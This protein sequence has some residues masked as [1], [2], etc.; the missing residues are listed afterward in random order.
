MIFKISLLTAALLTLNL[1]AEEKPPKND[2]IGS[3][4]VS[5]E[6]RKQEAI[7][8]RRIAADV[9]IL[10]WRCK[11]ITISG[12]DLRSIELAECER[13]TVR[14][15]W[16][17]DSARIGVEI[18]K[19]RQVRVE[20]CRIEN[21]MSGV[22]AVESQQVQVVENFV[23]NVK[24]PFPRGQ[25]VQFDKVSGADNFIR[26]N[27]ATNEHR[28]SHP[29]DVISIYLSSGEESSPIL[30]E[31]NYLTGDSSRGSEGMS[32][33]GSGIM[34]GDSGGGHMLCRRNVILS[35]GQ[36]GIGVA[37]G[38]FIRIEDNLIHGQ[39]SNVSNVGLYVWNQSGQPSRNVSV[40]RNRVQWL[41]RRGE[42][43]SWWNGGKV[44]NIKENENRFGDATLSAKLPAPPAGPPSKRM[45]WN[46][47]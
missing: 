1:S 16:I 18:S 2:L 13:V 24:G 36:V 28:K 47:E 25:M 6:G 46:S 12:C 17:H 35:A 8:A 3:D 42:Q 27:H 26:G 7:N 40:L 23:R 33:S 41:N 43:N 34:L 4:A 9:S 5:W 14:N 15:C 37:G 11:D 29:E 22:Y 31:D 20:S 39:K 10:L 38:S 44:E 21:V 19:S 30:I 32:E 45:P